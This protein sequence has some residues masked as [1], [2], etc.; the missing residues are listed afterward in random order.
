[1]DTLRRGLRAWWRWTVTF[2][3]CSLIGVAL[4]L[5]VVWISQ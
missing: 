2:T 4:A 1:M 3:V 5:L